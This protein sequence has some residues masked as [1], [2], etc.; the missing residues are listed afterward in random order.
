MI[1]DKLLW[2]LMFLVDLFVVV[3]LC[4]FDCYLVILE[5]VGEYDYL[6]WL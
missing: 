4:Y 6:Y 2:Y 3:V 5:F 1:L